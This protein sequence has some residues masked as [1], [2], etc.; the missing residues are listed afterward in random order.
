MNDD[1]SRQ[2]PRRRRGPGTSKPLP[3]FDAKFL[4]GIIDALADPVFVK[5]R[6]HRWVLLNDAYCRF[7]GYPRNELLGRSD[8]DF[9]PAEEAAV[10]WA[11]D[12][13]VFD[14][15][16]E[17][18]NEERFTDAKGVTHVIITKKAIF[19]SA[20]GEQLLVGVI[21]DVTDLRMAQ[22][23]LEAHRERLEELVRD[24]TA[25]LRDTN[26]RLLDEIEQRR[27]GEEERRALDAQMQQVQKLESLGLM[28]GGIAHDFNNLLSGI[29]GNAD[30]ALARL[31]D[32]DP[33]RP[34]VQE[35][36]R[37]AL[38][39]AG[40]TNQMLAYSGRG[41]FQIESLDLNH[42]IRDLGDLLQAGM[43]RKVM[44]RHVF[45]DDLPPVRGDAAQIR[46]VVMNLITNAAEAI[47]EGAG[48]VTLRTWA[49]DHGG[50]PV[51][52]GVLNWSLPPGRYVA[53]TVEDTGC[54][55]DEATLARIFDPFF[56]TKNTG[57]GLG[58][59]AVLGIARGHDGA[60]TV[61]T[62]PG[63]GSTF[64]MLLPVARTPAPP[65]TTDEPHLANG[66]WLGHGTALV[67]DD[68]GMV[69]AVLSGM[70]EAL[71]FK[72]ETAGDGLQ[73]LAMVDRIGDSLVLVLLD[74]T[75][76][77]MSGA[78]TLAE[79]RARRPN[80]PIVLTSGYG[81]RD[82]LAEADDFLQKPFTFEM[83]QS[84]VRRLLER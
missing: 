45:A 8:P 52:D 30:L 17:N 7:M 6:E 80:L 60:L 28:A 67:V 22:Q 46:Q 14:A 10:F 76:P 25:A 57:R 81:E 78:E 82:A 58:L 32:R 3:L 35:I 75:M 66:R 13:Q 33:V 11:R 83:L 19:T 9:F 1:G 84:K 69:R 51:R 39:S 50:G 44:V 26:A 54:G 37:A 40:L 62:A 43:S 72:V 79:L 56:T 48:T 73:A 36:R 20:D 15:G 61:R 41:H 4:S 16:V 55:L 2:S 63:R 12:D 27:R 59:A 65:Q 29:L 18:V 23:A 5:D 74:L 68:D 42:L 71:G 77:Q 47:E 34:F 64:G 21:R 49:L 24:R 31:G 38:R 70:L 53:F